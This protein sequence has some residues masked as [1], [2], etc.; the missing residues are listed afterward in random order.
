MLFR[1]K[2]VNGETIYESALNTKL[3]Q[4]QRGSV[5]DDYY[6]EMNRKDTLH[7]VFD[8]L[9]YHNN[10]DLLNV[11][12]D[13]WEFLA[14]GDHFRT[15]LVVFTE[16]NSD[17]YVGV[18]PI[19]MNLQPMTAL[20]SIGR[21][22]G[23]HQPCQIG[24]NF[25]NGNKYDVCYNFYYLLDGE[26]TIQDGSLSFEAISAYGSLITGEFE[27]DFIPYKDW[28]KSSITPMIKQ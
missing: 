28:N 25:K 11:D 6:Y 17:S 8:E 27:G 20:Y 1:S 21:S 16:R 13:Y 26:I 5:G 23:S 19:S 9:I 15:Y 3:F 7:M 24:Y 14:I 2:L 22:Y 10:G 18:Y 4:D 12:A